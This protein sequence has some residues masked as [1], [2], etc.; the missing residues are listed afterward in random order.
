[1]LAVA[2]NREVK[3]ILGAALTNQL[4]WHSTNEQWLDISSAEDWAG[5]FKRKKLIKCA[6]AEHVFEHL[7][8]KQMEK[9]LGLIYQHMPTGS[10]IRIAVPD[11]NHPKEEYRRNTGIGGIGDDAADHKQFLTFE[12]LKVALELAGFS[13]IHQEGYAKDGSLKENFLDPKFGYIKR[14]RSA[15]KLQI[16]SEG[17]NFIDSQTSLVVDGIKNV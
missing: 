16:E 2:R 3:V 10:T 7:T 9:A 11:G 5:I 13:V 8:P 15:S 17:W 4:G 14:S 1:M 12:T 6:V